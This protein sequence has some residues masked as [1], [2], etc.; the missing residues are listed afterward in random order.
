MKALLISTNPY[1]SLFLAA[2]EAN[3]YKTELAED[4][5]QGIELIKNNVYDVIIT[6]YILP[7]YN[8]LELLDGINGKYHL[9]YNPKTIMYSNVHTPKLIDSAKELGLDRFYAAP[10]DLEAIIN[11]IN[12]GLA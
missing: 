4:G 8:G 10:L 9:P 5:L 2:L 1:A 6:G 12:T 7:Y 3:G 11:D